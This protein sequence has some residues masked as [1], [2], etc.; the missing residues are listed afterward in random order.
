MAKITTK[1]IIKTANLAMIE[2]DQKN[3]QNLCDQISN[4]LEWVEKLNEVDTSGVVPLTTVCEDSLILNNDIVNDGNIANEILQ[5]ANNPKYGY[6]SVPK[7]I[8]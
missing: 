7:V 6:F 4:V 8:E 5:N 2:V 3:Q 1:D